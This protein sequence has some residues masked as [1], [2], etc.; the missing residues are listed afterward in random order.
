MPQHDKSQLAVRFYATYNASEPVRE[1]LLDLSRADRQTIGEDI[2]TVQFGWPLGMPL[3]RK[4]EPGLW[5]VRSQL[6]N[7]IARVLFTTVDR[8]LVLVH[9]VIKKR[10]KL[11]TSDL[12]LA[13]S[14]MKE[15]RNG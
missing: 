3:V 15:V 9:G 10:Q 7:G 13:R 8:T 4:L 5:E 14:R 1:W 2:R 12:D 6:R 11:A